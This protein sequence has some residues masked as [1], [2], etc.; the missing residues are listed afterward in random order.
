[1]YSIIY[2][3]LSNLVNIHS[4]KAFQQECNHPDISKSFLYIL[5]DTYMNWNQTKKFEQLIIYFLLKFKQT[6]FSD[7]NGN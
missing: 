3:N 4:S 6:S 1:M 7:Q 5:L 2:G